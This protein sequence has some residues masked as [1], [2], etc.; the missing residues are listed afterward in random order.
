MSTRM[1]FAVVILASAVAVPAAAAPQVAE[2]D[3]VFR[4]VRFANGES[5]PEVRLHYRT[6][7]APVRDAGGVVRNAVL[8]LHGTGG[9]GGQFLQ[10]QFADQ[11]F[12]EG[13]LL[14]PAKY[15]VVMP[16]NLG[17]GGSTKPSDGLHMTFPR[18]A[19]D[20]MVRLQYRLLTEHLKVT[21]L[22]L[23]MGT[24]MGGMHAWMWGYMYPGAMDGLVPLAS[25]PTAIAGRNRMWRRMLMDAIMDDPAWRKGEYAVPPVLGLRAA[26]R[27]QMILTSAPVYWQSMAPTREAADAFIDQEVGKRA[28]AL[29]AN[30][31]LYQYDASRDYDPSSH[32]EQIAAPVLAINSADDQVNPPELGLM[33]RLLPRVGRVKYVLIPASVETRGHSSH[34]W[35]ALWKDDFTAFVASL[36]AR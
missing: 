15:F 18:Y 1:A 12:G 22:R 5:L 33:E 16:D 28:L 34:T 20:D 11:M 25:V 17:H 23:V 32:L 4:D 10:P 2:G 30:D 26:V 35:A 36:P 14:D 21:H 13:Q 6:L 19:Y 27:I 3:A 9:T 8:L 24:S 7:G 29:D 31:T